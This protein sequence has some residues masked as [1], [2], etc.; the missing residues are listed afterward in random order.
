MMDSLD[1]GN[2]LVVLLCTGNDHTGSGL[3]W[4]SGL[5]EAGQRVVMVLAGVHELAT[6]LVVWDTLL[7]LYWLLDLFIDLMLQ[8]LADGDV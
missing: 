7:V 1:H 2:Q 4:P 5:L 8:G 6:G 3:N